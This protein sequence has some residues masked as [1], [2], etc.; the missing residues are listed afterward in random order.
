MIRCRSNFVLIRSRQG[1][2][3]YGFGV[4]GGGAIVP[5]LRRGFGQR[6]S[7]ILLVHS[8]ALDTLLR[9]VY[10]GMNMAMRV[11]PFLYDIVN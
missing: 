6:K 4:T 5:N 8:R 2:R 9:V 3:Y 11:R 10:D 7:R 1:R